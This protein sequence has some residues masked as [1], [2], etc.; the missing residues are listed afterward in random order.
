MISVTVVTAGVGIAVVD[1]FGVSVC[2]ADV[3]GDVAAVGADC[4]L[5]VATVRTAGQWSY[6]T[7]ASL[8]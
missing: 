8:V 1:V 4:S 5:F 6:S 3:G 2:V 7:T